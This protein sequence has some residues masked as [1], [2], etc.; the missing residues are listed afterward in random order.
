VLALDGTIFQGWLQ[1]ANDV[2]Y[3]RIN[4]VNLTTF[5]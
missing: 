5:W 2:D 3:Y 1:Q 4:I